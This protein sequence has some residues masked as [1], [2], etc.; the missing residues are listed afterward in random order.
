MLT[1]VK[2][3]YVVLTFWI[4]LGFKVFFKIIKGESIEEQK[5]NKGGKRTSHPPNASKWSNNPFYPIH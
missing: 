3:S 2:I 5:I 1:L 4:F